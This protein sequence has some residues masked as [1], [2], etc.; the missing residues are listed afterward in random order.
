D[1]SPA[2]G[3]PLRRNW[4]SSLTDRYVFQLSLRGCRKF[5]SP[6][7]LTLSRSHL[8]H[9]GIWFAVII[10]GIPEQEADP[11]FVF[12]YFYLHFNVFRRVRLGSPRKCLQPRPDHYSTPLSNQL[13][14][15]HRLANEMFGRISR[16]LIAI[17]SKEVRRIN[18][19]RKHIAM[20][21]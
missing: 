9:G 7:V 2:Y 3:A 18:H 13:E 20:L 8:R 12:C 1:F 11:A 10:I 5:V 14:A 19:R 16:M 4:R 6:E 21:R 17:H 15:I